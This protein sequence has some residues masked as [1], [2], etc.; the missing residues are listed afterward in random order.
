MP[1]LWRKTSRPK[2]PRRPLPLSVLA[3]GAALA[4][5]LALGQGS[6]LPGSVLLGAGVLLLASAA[7]SAAH[8]ERHDGAAQVGPQIPT[9][10]IGGWRGVA[11]LVFVLGLAVAFRVPMQGASPPGLAA[12]EARLGLDAVRVLTSGLSGSAW[13]GWPIFH[14]LTVSSIAAF[15][16]TPLAVR[17]PAILGGIA[18]AAAL[19][20]LGRQLGGTLLGSIAGV[21]GAALFWH[22][23]STRAAWG[24]IAWS[25]T[26]ETLGVALLLYASRAKRPVSAGFAGILLGLALQVSWSAVPAILV[27]VVLAVRWDSGAPGWRLPARSVLMPFVVY[28]AIAAGPVVVGIATPDR[29]VSL[30][31]STDVEHQESFVQRVMGLALLSNLGGDQNPLHSLNGQAQLDTITAALLVLGVSMAVVYW[32][33]KRGGILILWLLAHLGIAAITSRSASPNSFAA[34]H[35]ITPALLLAAS[36][37]LA[38][39]GQLPDTPTTAPRWRLD[40][41]LLLL[42]GMIAVNAHSLYVKRPADAATWTAFGSAEV[43]A[44]KQIAKLLP[45]STIYLADVWLDDPTIRFLTPGMGEPRRVDGSTTLPLRQDET[46]AYFA[47]GRQ[48]VVA[49]DLERVYED[50][51]IDRFR[52]PLDD[53]QVV[54]RTFRAPAK[55]VAGTRGVTLRLTSPDR[56]KNSR[57]TLPEF[58]LHWPMQGEA[59]RG[60][61]LDLFTALAVDTAGSYRFRLDGPIGATL[62]INGAPVS[63]AGEDVVAALAGGAQRVR[64]VATT[65][66]ESKISLRWQPPGTTELTTIPADRLY[67]EQRVASGLLAAY[68]PLGSS[69]TPSDVWRV[70]RYVQREG[71]QPPVQ[72]PYTLDLTGTLDAP[73]AGA[74]RFRLS[75]N[76]PVGMWIGGQPVPLGMRPTDEPASLVLTEGDHEIRLRLLDEVGPTSFN[77][78]WAPPGEDWGAIPTSRFNPPTGPIDAAPTPEQR[79]DAAVRALGTPRVLWLA[80]MEGEPRAVAVGPDG[81]VYVTNVVTRETQ[82]I[83]D[84]GVPPTAVPES[85]ASVPADVEVGPDGQV[86]ILDAL[87]GQLRRIDP[88]NGKATIVGGRELGLYR[89]RGFALAPDGTALIADT[90]GSRIVRVTADGTILATIGPDVGGPARVRQPTDVAVATNGEIYAVNGEGGTVLRLTPSGAYLGHWNVLP[91]DTERGSHLAVGP[92]GSI[93]ISEPDGR[94][95]SRFTPAGV[96]AGV[97]DQT[98]EGR[99]LRGPVGIAVGADGTLYVADVSLRAVLAIRFQP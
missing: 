95:I 83:T 50:G 42:G 35:A 97:V 26:C 82:R 66:G 47:P 2:T 43:M 46:F 62:E 24:Y 57:H 71:N 84:P 94:R 16:Q 65:D 38:V 55:V 40:L 90:G 31:P 63:R 20:C 4:G 91:A 48:E 10:L 11:A 32:R 73:K 41:L 27:G 69:S 28:L 87:D 30:T 58:A 72:R 34:F 9:G 52:S 17:L 13:D 22:A 6:W 7:V 70:E 14:L 81:A 5:Q 61:T 92:D 56:S 8:I 29:H 79:P 23:D 21:L 68:R 36:G 15:G 33:S 59:S 49:E 44:A 3:L 99:M 1:I 74:Y 53:T 88:S 37:L 12:D 19:F 51:E 60:A 76:G 67:R 85:G 86:W 78:T 45:S 89:P 25:L 93:W 77:L 96:P 64:V 75:G 39:S 54:L 80:S 98:R 18:F